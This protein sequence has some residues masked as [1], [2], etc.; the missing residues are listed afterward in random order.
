[1]AKHGVRARVEFSWGATEVKPPRLADAIVEVT[2]TGSSLRANNLRIVAEVLQSTPR[3]IANHQA[4]ADPWKRQKID[5]MALMLQ[6]AMA[7]EGK[8]GL[9]MNVPRDRLRQVLALLPALQ[10]PTVASL[11]DESWVAVNTVLD[12]TIVR[13]IIPRLKTAGARGIVEYPLSKIIE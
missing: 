9:M 6:G 12:E 10:K 11:A 7:A 4:Y 3:L 1:L 2:E 5:D 8:V 13:H